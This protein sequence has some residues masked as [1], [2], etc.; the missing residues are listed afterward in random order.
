MLA[1]LLRQRCA[2]SWPSS[3]MTFSRSSMHCAAPSRL[4]MSAKIDRASSS[5]DRA[6][7][8]WFCIREDFA[9]TLQ[10]LRSPESIANVNENQPCIL[11]L[12]SGFLILVLHPQ[13]FAETLQALCSP[14]SI[15]NVNENRLCILQ[16][17]SGLLI[18]VLHP[19]DFAETLQAV[20]SPGRS[21]MSMKIRPCILQLQSG[22][23]ILVLHPQ[24]FAETLQALGSPES[25]ANCQ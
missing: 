14:E 18:L 7:S 19:Q 8:Y 1:P 16:L 4:P 17:R 9:E 24:D 20:G 22:F 21:P 13:D 15:A 12:R 5:F 2:S 11:Q 10:A 3:R 25:I 6:S 23:L